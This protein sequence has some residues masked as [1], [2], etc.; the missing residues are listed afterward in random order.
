M[1]TDS[2]DGSAPFSITE[3][4]SS[5]GVYIEDISS[6]RLYHQEWKIVTH[7]NMTEYQEEYW[8]LRNL[9]LNIC[10][11]CDIYAEG[12][13]RTNV[14]WCKSVKHQLEGLLGD[15]E[16]NN[17]KWW[18]PT[19]RAK[20][21]LFN[22]I[23]LISNQLFGTLSQEDAERYLSMFEQLQQDNRI[24]DN[25]IDTQTSLIESIVDF[26]KRDQKAAN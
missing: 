20:R 8:A 18:I 26:G 12:H 14:P 16:I 11:R 24:R 21:G 17:A 2:E 10:H 13:Q 25:M 9:G 5:A 1:S 3:I 19:T 6:L 15:L 7:I 4:Q 22:V 23:G